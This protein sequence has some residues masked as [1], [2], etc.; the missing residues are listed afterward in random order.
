VSTL[1]SSRLSPLAIAGLGACAL[2][3]ALPL[4][5][6]AIAFGAVAF[7]VGCVLALR[8]TTAPVITWVHA[9]TLLVFIVWLIPIK[10]YRLP[11]NLP[12][13]LEVY[14]LLVLLLMVGWIV[15]ALLGKVHLEAGGGGKPLLLL[16]AGALASQVVNFGDIAS[17]DLGT[18]AIKSLS[19][20]ISYL[21]VFVL[22]YS[23]IQTL[24]DINRVVKALV[25]G[26]V[27]VA[28]AALYEARTKYNLF[29]HLDDWIPALEQVRERSESVR[30]SRVRAFA[31]G[32]HPIALGSAL[33]LTA[34]FAI[35]LARQARTRLGLAFWVSAAAVLIAGAFATVSRTIVVMLVPM[36]IAALWL[37]RREAIRL[38][39]LLLL[40]PAAVHVLAPG[41]LGTLYRTIQPE[42][43]VVQQRGYA[44]PRASGRLYDVGPGLELWRAAPFLG[45][46]LGTQP[47]TGTANETASESPTAT[48]STG[49]TDSSNQIIFDDEYLGTLVSLGIVGF[50][51]TIWLVWGA[52]LKCG[53]AA[54][55][56]GGQAGGILVA[57]SAAC[58]G[59]AF[60]MGTYDAF[61][62]VQ[63]SLILFVIAA[64]GLRAR[65]LTMATPE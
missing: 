15:S 46:A 59:F 35:Y 1:E 13:N 64:L 31:S 43:V 38:W 17:A 37:R 26:G 18:Q 23:S 36:V 22:V 6:R 20:F 54:K 10:S 25:L 39:P 56:I 3:V 8:D 2:V 24:T 61:S 60:G 53:I 30:G 16:A 42:A 14:R 62:F 40:L 7:L 33:V 41:T 58:F 4:G 11:V 44:G 27:I 32:Q 48:T 49:G 50:L 9:I 47:T 5:N 63:A 52:A 51:G 28:I 45:H 19:F 57:S 12:F 34:P 65:A 21:I 55:K 29:T